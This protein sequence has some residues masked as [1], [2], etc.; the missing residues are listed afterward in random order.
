MSRKK[1]KMRM[2]SSVLALSMLVSAFP[3]NVFAEDAAD[4]QAVVET[5]AN[6][7]ILNYDSTSK[8]LNWEDEISNQNFYW[9]LNDDQ[10]IQRVSSSDP[11]NAA[12][13]SFDGYYINA[14][15]KTVLRLIYNQYSQA[16]SSWWKELQVRFDKNLY[17][18]IDWQKSGIRRASDAKVVPFTDTNRPYQ[19]SV[20]M[21]GVA[22][23]T[24]VSRTFFLPVELVLKD[25]DIQS[26]GNSIYYVQARVESSDG[27]YVYAY[28]PKG[29]NADYTSYTF[30]TPIVVGTRSFD[31]FLP[32]SI[33]D[34]P[35][36]RSQVRARVFTAS[37]DPSHN[38]KDDMGKLSLEYLFRHSA[39][40]EEV[41]NNSTGKKPY[42]FV[43]GFDKK[44]VDFLPKG[45]SQTVVGNTQARNSNKV[46]V[47]NKSTI[48]RENV[49]VD[50]D[51]AYV[52]VV[53]N[54]FAGYQT[55]DKKNID[56]TKAS[57][58]VA[59]SMTS[60]VISNQGMDFATLELF[61]S[62]KIASS[63]I[64]DDSNDGGI[65][66]Y[67]NFIISA[68]FVFPNKEGWDEFTYTFKK[69]TTIPDNGK[70]SFL[71]SKDVPGLYNSVHTTIT[72][73]QNN[74]RPIN[75]DF[76][77]YYQALGPDAFAFGKEARRGHVESLDKG[78]IQEMN[79][80]GGRQIKKGDKLKVWVENPGFGG[81][82]M[83]I[84]DIKW[85]ELGKTT[86]DAGFR[87]SKKD[88]NGYIYGQIPYAA[89]GPKAK[90]VDLKYIDSKTNE[91]KTINITRD[92]LWRTPDNSI[93]NFTNASVLS[94]GGYFTLDARNFKP[95]TTATLVAHMDNNKDQTVEIK[96]T[97]EVFEQ[98]GKDT[99]PYY[100][101][102]SNIISMMS[103]RK[104]HYLP[105]QE[106]FTNDYTGIDIKTDTLGI[107]EGDIVGEGN[108]T[109]EII[110]NFD[111]TGNKAKKDS[112]EKFNP[113]K[114]NLD[115]FMTARTQLRGYTRYSGGSVVNAIFPKDV[116][117]LSHKDP[118]QD[119]VSVTS[120]A[121]N[122]QTDKDGKVILPMY[123][124]VSVDGKDYKAYM[125]ALSRPKSLVLK[126]D[127]QVFFTNSE[128]SSLYSKWKEER[129]RAR[130]LFDA[131]TDENFTV[132]KT[133][134]TNKDNTV[135]IVPDNSK[136]TQDPSYVANGFSEDSGAVLTDDLGKELSQ[137]EKELRT[138]PEDPKSITVEGKEK[139]FLGWATKKVTQEEFEKLKELKTVDQWKDATTTGY[140][141]TKDSPF[142]SHQVLYAVYG[143]GKSA[144][145]NPVQKYDDDND[146]QYIEATP[147]ED[148]K[149]APTA[150]QKLVKKTGE[151]AE[152]NPTYEEI[153]V[154][155]INIGGKDVFD[156][157]GENSPVKHGDE[158]YIMTK[159]EGKPASYSETPVR[160]DKK[161]PA[162]TNKNGVAGINVD[163]DTYGYKLTVNATAT[164][165]DSAIYK[166]YVDGHDDEGSYIKKDVGSKTATINP[167]IK[168]GGQ[169]I[170]VKVIAM[171][172][173]GNKAEIESKEI[174]V[175]KSELRISADVPYEGQDVLYI[176]TTPGAKLT[177]TVT[178]RQKNVKLTM[179]HNQETG[180]DEVKLVGEDGSP[181]EL[182]KRDKVVITGNTESTL[183]STLIMRAR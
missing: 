126:K 172:I 84:E 38:R 122:D 24:Y 35:Y 13:L 179:T 28:A 66:N 116:V 158:I 159:E 51:I 163:Q 67:K 40:A 69:D 142:D 17:D 16:A 171:D 75:K 50:G 71:M 45:D 73:P 14:E 62:N 80:L 135:K 91:E 154:P 123:S 181:F 29:S 101:H 68:G 61:V 60:D 113:Y 33:T 102:D 130:V 115:K 147:A 133:S 170:K 79:F 74:T 128:E 53:N 167:T 86:G 98:N 168:H 32:G 100:M 106:I 166:L 54:K 136:Y 94:S 114:D 109:A 112:L 42:G 11:L 65:T 78:K 87:I 157:T 104:A 10:I 108:D 169:T 43:V 152:D 150:T 15:G 41:Q 25:N 82:P 176:Q 139:Q 140:V 177:I 180:N 47:G 97:G 117:D 174:G 19:K 3:A 20:T 26:L 83:F 5:V 95:G 145:Y 127:M 8:K 48:K 129:V 2:T 31:Q 9:P 36:A 37:Y 21:S 141:V 183:E 175:T 12:S 107:T 77:G 121:L 148:G 23:M 178:D 44:I 118:K 57:P 81:V 124:K 88:N 138:W 143:E 111:F 155:V 85:N 30:T 7:S 58:V 125:Y 103:L 39:L 34:D 90:S 46:A 131:N 56:G 146:K 93:L 144:V 52:M 119:G 153:N 70:L 4:D 92:S 105:K 110:Q 162:I 27:K 99:R 149:E 89:I 151:D 59:G 18:K 132:E 64:G 96:T 55:F 160:I 173:L 63:Y 49:F 161:A 182:A 164:D 156:I 72:N 1:L 165:E 137:E 134:E 22:N 120:H 76:L 6:K